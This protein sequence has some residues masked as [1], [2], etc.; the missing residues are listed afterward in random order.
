M[1]T[2]GR[3]LVGTWVVGSA[4]TGTLAVLFTL[5]R[6]G[7]LVLPLDRLPVLSQVGVVGML[8]ALFA[9]LALLGWGTVE[10]TWLPDTGRGQALWTVLVG[11]AGLVGWAFAAAATFAGRFTLPAQL[12]LGYVGGGLPFVLV[13]AMLLRPERVNAAAVG[14]TAVLLL[15]GTVIMDGRPLQ[16]C[17]EMLWYVFGR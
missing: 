17:A 10:V 4:T 14:V 16:V 7:S 8:A 15:V 9:A 1:N 5:G 6:G 11:G 2:V 13:A 12:V 3:Q